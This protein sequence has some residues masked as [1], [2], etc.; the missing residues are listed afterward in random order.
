M[1][2]E[3]PDQD[4]LPTEDDLVR[5]LREYH[6][7]QNR[8]AN[9]RAYDNIMRQGG[10]DRAAPGTIQDWRDSIPSGGGGGGHD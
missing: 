3:S 5:R 4:R 2:Y 8:Y 6:I 9:Q 1:L 10:I 7:D